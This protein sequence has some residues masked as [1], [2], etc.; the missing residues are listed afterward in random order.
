MKMKQLF[1][2]LLAAVVIFALLPAL[3][4][5]HGQEATNA[6]GADQSVGFPSP[7]QVSSPNPTITDAKSGV[8]SSPTIVT[9]APVSFAPLVQALVAVGLP[10]LI[11]W[12]KQ[13]IPQDKRKWIPFFAP[14]LGEA[15]A[16]VATSLPHGAGALAGLAG[17]GVR[18]L[19]DQHFPAAEEPNQSGKGGGNNIGAALGVIFAIVAWSSMIIVPIATTGCAHVSKQS[20]YLGD[21]YAYDTDLVID[22][23]YT[24]L[25]E[26]VEWETAN[27]EFVKANWPEVAKFAQELIDNGDQWVDDALD[28]RDAYQANPTPENRSK[29]ERAVAVLRVA[30]SKAAIYSAKR[31]SPQPVPG[32]TK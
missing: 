29:L 27:H 16:S 10:L 3:F 22:G 30:L 23:A 31:T 11:A 4:F 20:V 26:F 32:G 17:V 12:L 1:L 9:N 28:L 2:V 7:P 5:V 24:V 6:T 25:N 19:K 18:E 13:W 14:I 8:T 15:L 21:Q